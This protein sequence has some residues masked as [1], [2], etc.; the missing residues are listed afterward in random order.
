M[1]IAI[2]GHAASGK[3]TV[4][5]GVSKHL[6]FTYLNTGAMYRALTF[7]IKIKNQSIFINV[8]SAVAQN[9]LKSMRIY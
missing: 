7:G 4:A 9:L 2:D 6:G 1:I 5:R 3:S 8:Y